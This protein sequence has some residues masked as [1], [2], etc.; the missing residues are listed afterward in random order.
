MLVYLKKSH[1][2]G[3]VT[4]IQMAI[5]L[6]QADI[7]LCTHLKRLYVTKHRVFGVCIIFM[8]LIY[9]LSQKIIMFFNYRQKRV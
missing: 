9:I 4:Q 2:Y 7:L 8:N 5:G 6:C 3:Y 1:T